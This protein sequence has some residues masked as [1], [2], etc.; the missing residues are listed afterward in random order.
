MN[1]RLKTIS[2]GLGS[3]EEESPATPR[4]KALSATSWEINEDDGDDS[5]D[6]HEIESPNVWLTATVWKEKSGWAGTFKK[7]TSQLLPMGHYY[8][9]EGNLGAALL[10]DGDD[11]GS[12]WVRRKIV[13]DG[14]FLMYYHAKAKILHDEFPEIGED[15]SRAHDDDHESHDKQ[16]T[17]TSITS[18]FDANLSPFKSHPKSAITVLQGMWYNFEETIRQHQQKLGLIKSPST[19]STPATHLHKRDTYLPHQ[20]SKVL[21]AWDTPR[22][23]ID[24]HASDVSVSI[25]P[26]SHS[27]STFITPIPPT[28]FCLVIK[29][30]KKDVKWKFCFDCREEMFKWLAVLSDVVVNKNV[31]VYNK[32]HGAYKYPE[33]IN[34]PVSYNPLEK[35][36]AEQLLP[37]LNSFDTSNPSQTYSDRAPTVLD[38]EVAPSHRTYRSLSSTVHDIDSTVPSRP[39]LLRSTSSVRSTAGPSMNSTATNSATLSPKSWVLVGSDLY[40][41]ILVINGA[42][43]YAFFVGASEGLIFIFHIIGCALLA[44]SGLFLF[45]QRYNGHQTS[46][47]SQRKGIVSYLRQKG[48]ILVSFANRKLFP[49]RYGNKSMDTLGNNNFVTESTPLILTRGISVRDKLSSSRSIPIPTDL[50]SSASK[51]SISINSHL[52]IP[53]SNM[54]VHETSNISILDRGSYENVYGLNTNRSLQMPFLDDSNNDVFDPSL[55]SLSPI[56]PSKPIAGSTTCQIFNSTDSNSIIL[57]AP[58]RTSITWLASP[59]TSIDVRGPDYM[60]SRKKTPCCHSLYKL[61]AVDLFESSELIH[62]IAP[63]FQ[64][65]ADTWFSKCQVKG[66]SSPEQPLWKSPDCFVV[67]IALPASTRDTRGYVLVGYY[68]MKEETRAVLEMISQPNYTP[69]RDDDALVKSNLSYRSLINGVKLWERWCKEAPSNTDMQSR[70]KFLARGD[71]LKEIGV[72]KW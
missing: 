49:N 59:S 39:T 22:G 66:S 4:A 24:F 40:K 12:L 46:Q 5:E 37:T 48:N 38:E 3:N 56:R 58:D 33:I 26:Q 11:E 55:Y 70:F 27:S 57:S 67:S 23:V 31:R 17:R 20:D 63:R 28:P 7:K 69:N 1:V 2:T 53:V 35:A 14:H 16:T 71:N 34:E 18:N 54:K 19:P 42:I 10:Q 72:M 52:T 30:N 51:S 9:E 64:V 41:T 13:L 61:M 50:L 68:H 21:S 29:G 60:T 43:L 47:A 32:R 62:P 15:T 65:Q 25:V 8:N 45:L 6:E 36:V 44:N